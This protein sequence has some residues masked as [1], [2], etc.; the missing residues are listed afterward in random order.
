V[1]GARVRGGWPL[2]LCL[3]FF[4]KETAGGLSYC[5]FKRGKKKEGCREKKQKRGR[6]FPGLLDTSVNATVE[7]T[8]K[9]VARV[10]ISAK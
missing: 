3:L 1:G 2:S 8:R 4:Q 6:S 5:E 10:K 7:K 9:A